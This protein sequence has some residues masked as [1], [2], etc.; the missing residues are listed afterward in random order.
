MFRIAAISE[1]CFVNH[2]AA[3]HQYSNNTERMEF[4]AGTEGLLMNEK[5]GT[6]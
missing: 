5:G 4:S 3:N 6:V 1:I 2:F